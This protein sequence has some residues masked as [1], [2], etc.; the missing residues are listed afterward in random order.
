MVT[1]SLLFM[2]KTMMMMVLIP[3]DDYDDDD[4]LITL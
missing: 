1:W 2:A 3:Y 4:G